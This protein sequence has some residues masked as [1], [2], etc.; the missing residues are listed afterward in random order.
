MS[1]DG[2][3]YIAHGL[4]RIRII[5]TDFSSIFNL[6]NLKGRGFIS[7]WYPVHNLKWL[8]EFGVTWSGEKRFLDMTFVQP[9]AHI[10]EYFGS[11]V[12]FFFLWTG[13]YCK[14]LLMLICVALPAKILLMVVANFYS[15]PPR[16][17]EQL[18]NQIFAF[19]II[20]WTKIAEMV[21]RREQDFFLELW[22]MTSVGNS[23]SVRAEFVG[24]LQP[25]DVDRRIMELQAPA[26]VQR[27]KRMVSNLFILVCGICV[28]VCINIWMEIFE[29]RLNVFAST[30]LSVQILVL[31]SI[32][33]WVSTKLTDWENHRTDSSYFNSFLWKIF[34][35]QF[36]NNYTPFFY[37]AVKMPHTSR[38]C[39]KEGCLGMLKE[40]LFSTLLILS[41]A[42]IAQ[43]L[44][45]TLEVR[46]TLY[47]EERALIKLKGEGAKVKRS[48]EEEQSKYKEFRMK[49]QIAA[50][51]DLVITLGFVFIFG[52]VEPFFIPLCLL[53][54]IVQLRATAFFLCTS[55]KRTI[56]RWMHGIGDWMDVLFLLRMIGMLFASFL[57][58]MSGSMFRDAKLTTKLSGFIVICSV[59]FLLWTVVDL[60][61]AEDDAATRL[62]ARR[63]Y[64]RMELTRVIADNSEH[65]GAGRAGNRRGSSGEERTQASLESMANQLHL[66]HRHSD[67][68]LRK[69]WNSIPRAAEDGATPR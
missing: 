4:E 40:N 11:R 52:V 15:I 30:L 1:V 16:I 3:G 67:K 57:I 62:R 7:D 31:R 32:F 59:S 55:C 8:H 37:I 39:P 12:A 35:L 68:I 46:W 36:V 53:V 6:G 25:S 66:Q 47:A 50:F 34:L 18:L 42:R 22:D 29:G 13:I 58:V 5:H 20:M 45:S 14:L 60:V 48:F 65:A 23:D 24:T 51:N 28:A 10:R 27:L 49:D 44:Y 38:G 21:Y 61:F 26:H 64:V 17:Y 41:A 33:N 19:V 56:P 63:D 43:V 2:N 54:F 9:I 69:D